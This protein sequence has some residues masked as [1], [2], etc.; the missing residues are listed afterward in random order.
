M[1]IYFTVNNS[2]YANTVRPLTIM[3]GN[4]FEEVVYQTGLNNAEVIYEVN[5]DILILD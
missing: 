1:F 4:S 5:V 3:V 2:I